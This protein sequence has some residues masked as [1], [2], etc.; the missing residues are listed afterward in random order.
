[1]HVMH[2]IKARFLAELELA[3]TP[4]LVLSFDRAI[5]Q[6]Y[7]SPK[8]IAA[9]LLRGNE[10]TCQ[11]TRC[12]ISE[13]AKEGAHYCTT[14]SGSLFNKPRKFYGVDS[15]QTREIAGNLVR[16]LNIAGTTR[17]VGAS[18]W[19]G[20][21][22]IGG[23]AAAAD[24]PAPIGD[25]VGAAIIIGAAAKFLYDDITSSSRETEDE[26]YENY[27]KDVEICKIAKS[28][29]CYAQAMERYQACRFGRP[30]PP[31]SF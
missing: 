18:R 10:L 31:L 6:I 2:F 27:L 16:N 21:L 9:N 17:I 14:I 12:A 25:V 20:P 11:N 26:C 3:S 15:K 13:V 28:R 29:A 7:R 30:I 5:R 19:A 4:C 23:T 22:A 8:K 1:M 24:G